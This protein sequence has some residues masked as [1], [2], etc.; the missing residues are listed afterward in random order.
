MNWDSALLVY[1]HLRRDRPKHPQN[2][3]RPPDS[4]KPHRKPKQTQAL[5][6]D[7]GTIHTVNELNKLLDIHVKHGAVHTEA[8]SILTGALNYATATVCVVVRWVRFVLCAPP[9]HD[10]VQ[11]H[12]NVQTGSRDHDAHEGRLPPPGAPQ[13]KP[14]HISPPPQKNSN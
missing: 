4:P 6:E 11:T 10:T 9:S 1:V 8:G 13:N 7:I 3:H 5:G 12:T 2:I 14:G